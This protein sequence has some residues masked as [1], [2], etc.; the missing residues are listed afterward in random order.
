[1]LVV[2]VLLAE[3]DGDGGGDG[4][5][6]GGVGGGDAIITITIIITSKLQPLTGPA[7]RICFCIAFTAANTAVCDYRQRYTMH[8]K[9]ACI[10]IRDSVKLIN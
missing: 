7:C 2:E 4:C 6:C 3:V 5:C 8:A 9:S 10:S 1:M